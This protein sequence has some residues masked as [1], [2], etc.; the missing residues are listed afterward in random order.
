MD[1][2]SYCK[3][4][5]EGMLKYGTVDGFRSNTEGEYITAGVGGVLVS[6]WWMFHKIK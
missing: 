1:G 6:L 3:S 2:G 4:G 5:L